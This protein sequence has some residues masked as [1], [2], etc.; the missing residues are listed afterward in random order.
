MDHDRR[1][2][3]AGGLSLILRSVARP[4][5]RTRNSQRQD[6]ASMGRLKASE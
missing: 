2:G 6:F 1:T 4:G 3:D 5:A